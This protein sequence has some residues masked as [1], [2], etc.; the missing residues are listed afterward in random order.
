[1]ARFAQ[2][3]AAS[4]TL[5]FA[6][7]VAQLIAKEKASEQVATK[8]CDC[9]VQSGTCEYWFETDPGFCKYDETPCEKCVCVA[10]GQM[11]CEITTGAALVVTNPLNGACE[12]TKTTYAVCPADTPR[13]TATPT[14]AP[15]V[16]GWFMSAA[17]ESCTAKCA[18]VGATCN[19][20]MIQDLNSNA[21]LSTVFFGNFMSTEFGYTCPNY[22]DCTS[23]ANILPGTE[24]GSG[25]CIAASTQSAVDCADASGKIERVCCC[26]T[27]PGQCQL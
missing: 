4:M 20:L 17:G 9:E 18:A 3:V 12:V 6:V 14:P 16:G 8:T 22:S 24:F 5:M 1:M 11:T 23:C 7:S 2:I 13:P 19:P 25:T 15:A 21:A 27:A 10:G 26:E